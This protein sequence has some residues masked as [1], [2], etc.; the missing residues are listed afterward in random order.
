MKNFVASSSGK[1]DKNVFQTYLSYQIGLQSIVQSNIFFVRCTQKIRLA[2]SHRSGNADISKSIKMQKESL[3]VKRKR[4][5]V[6]LF[7]RWLLKIIC[8]YHYLIILWTF[9]FWISLMNLPKWVNGS[10]KQFNLI[11]YKRVAGMYFS[12][13]RIFNPQ[14]FIFKLK[15]SW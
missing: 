10:Y 1:N 5:N 13:A 4:F 9:F 11:R 7:F 8:Y 15:K 2:I 6:S 3:T 12:E 14:K